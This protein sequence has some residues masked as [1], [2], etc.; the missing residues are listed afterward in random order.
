MKFIDKYRRLPRHLR[1]E[2]PDSLYT[3]AGL[4][5]LFEKV[6]K[7]VTLKIFDGKHDV[8]YNA[9]LYWLS[10]QRRKTR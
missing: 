6:S 4:R 8:I 7:T 1:G 3:D 9:G 5:L 10:K 2:F